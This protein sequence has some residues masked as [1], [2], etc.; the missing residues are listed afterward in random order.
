MSLRE[1]TI[2]R[3]KIFKRQHNDAVLHATLN[4]AAY[5]GLKLPPMIKDEVDVAEPT[6]TPE[7]S[8]LH[9]KHLAGAQERKKQEIEARR[10]G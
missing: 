4:A 3:E 2:A 5:R 6:I 8:A 1:I 9:D 7:Q 10:R